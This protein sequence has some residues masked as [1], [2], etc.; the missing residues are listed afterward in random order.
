[1]EFILHKIFNVQLSTLGLSFAQLD[2][3]LGPRLSFAQLDVQ[4]STLAFFC[5]NRIQMCSQKKTVTQS[6][7][8]ET[9]SASCLTRRDF[10]HS[11]LTHDNNE[12]HPLEFSS[13]DPKQIPFILQPTG[14]TSY[15]VDWHNLRHRR[16]MYHIIKTRYNSF[17]S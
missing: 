14:V 9:K 5:T 2:V 11:L 17:C 10:E 8:D 7:R 6:S 13:L 16:K 15:S 12:Y 3:Q 4:V 1:M